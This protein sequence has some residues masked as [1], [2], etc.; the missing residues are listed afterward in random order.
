VKADRERIMPRE[1]GGQRAI[2]GGGVQKEVE[3]TQDRLQLQ[4][5]SGKPFFIK[6]KNPSMYQEGK[7]LQGKPN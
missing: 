6:G 4:M 1:S 2:E 7:V 5:V 3:K